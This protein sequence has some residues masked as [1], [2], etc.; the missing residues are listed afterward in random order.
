ML[1]RTRPW[2]RW[3]LAVA[4]LLLTPAHATPDR[5]DPCPDD[6]RPLID[7]LERRT[8][9]WFWDTGN[10]A[11]GLVPDRWPSPSAS[12]VAAVGFGLTAYG[13]G[14]ERGWVTRAQ[15][16]ERTRVTLRFLDSAPQ[17]AQP[18][19]TSGYRGFYY[20]LID[21]R[22]GLRQT[23]SELSSIDTALLLA[24]VLFAQSYFDGDAPAERDI[25]ALADRIY[26][27]VEWPWMQTRPP[28]IGMGWRP[29]R[30]F[31]VAD[32][33]GYNEAALLYVLALGSPTQPIDR[34]AWRAWTGT[35]SAQWGD[36]QGYTLLN[37][38]PL[39]GH[40]YSAAWIDFRGIRDADMRAR[41]SDYFENARK[42]TYTQRAYA[43]A[44]PN[45]WADYGDN[46]WG[47]TACD[48]P[49]GARLTVD[50]RERQFQGYLARGAAAG[51]VADDGT[52]APT[53]VVGS[54]AFAPEIAI[55]ALQ[56][57]HDRYGEH[58]YTRYGF[59]DAFNPTLR[60]ADV[61]PQT[62]T[63]IPDFGWVG[64]DYIGIDQGP[65]LL[66][67]ENY[68]SGL[69]WEVMRSNRYLR[70]GLERAGF[71]GGWL[72]KPARQMEARDSGR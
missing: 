11:N 42:A 22:H 4:A 6:T 30:G 51:Y 13:I 15:A 59:L 66:M 12:S 7:E 31:T 17:G 36:F 61:A 67:L 46:V 37:F 2:C 71:T 48:G 49:Q 24:G 19:G 45:R 72:H 44:N 23:D 5:S 14:A 1:A 9:R 25:R 56:T 26:R 68:R 52:I 35:H 43:I 16:A 29:E 20:H 63:L 64:H 34:A 41:G 60:R 10:P 69:V 8:F 53:A 38:G 3:L 40:Q 65:I 62:G 39:F 18:R 47:L 58:V 57:L 21:M 55:P 32:W 33:A 27:R 28:L 70:R 50:G 54:I